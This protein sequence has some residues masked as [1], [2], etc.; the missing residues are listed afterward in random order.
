M[1]CLSDPRVGAER[2][3]AG[4]GAAPRPAEDAWRTAGAPVAGCQGLGCG[5]A[6]GVGGLSG[7]GV[8]AAGGGVLA[9]GLRP[10]SAAG[11]AGHG[12]GA[13]AGLGMGGGRGGSV[14]VCGGAGVRRATGRAGGGGAAEPLSRAVHVR[15]V[16][17]NATVEE[18]INELGSYGPIE[19]ILHNPERSEALVAFVSPYDAGALLAAAGSLRVHDA[20]LELS[21]GKARPILPAVAE[22]IGAGATRNLYLGNLPPGTDTGRLHAAF[23]PFGPVE[24]VRVLRNNSTGYVNFCSVEAAVAAKSSFDQAGGATG[25]HIV[26]EL[27]DGSAEAA[28]QVQI[29]FTSAPQLARARRQGGAGPAGGAPVGGPPAA[30]T[31]TRSLKSSRSV[32]VGNLPPNCS[33]QELAQLASGQGTL[34][35]LRMVPGATYGFLNFVHERDA[36]AFWSA[37]QVT[38][39]AMRGN[40]LFLN[41]GKPPPIDPAVR[42]LVDEQGATRHL[43]VANISESTSA[44]QLSSLFRQ[45]GEVESVNLRPAEGAAQVN[46]TSIAAAAAAREQLHGLR[47]GDWE[48]L[49]KYVPA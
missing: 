11:M 2:L 49:V 19:S 12:L 26:P 31:D 18:L 28:A 32:Y 6:A 15:G 25:R 3:G 46:L 48:L 14:G 16:P 27:P 20:T 29:S 9:G 23:G 8:G 40:R 22:A 10:P 4:R 42:R 37:G 1:G 30:G 45:F 38:P 33:M 24:S 34:E 36:H 47:L 21:W 41:W 7:M 43:W 44:D 39:P 13:M 17:P 35:S 5:V